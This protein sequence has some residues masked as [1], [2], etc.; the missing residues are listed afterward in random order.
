MTPHEWRA[1]QNRVEQLWGPSQKWKE[2][3]ALTERVRLISFDTASAVVDALILAEKHAPAPAMIIGMALAR[4]GVT[5][6]TPPGPED[7]DHPRFGILLEG[8][9]DVIGQDS[10]LP[11]GWRLGMCAVCHVEQRFPP[12]RLLTQMEL[13]DRRLASQQPVDVY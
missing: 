9:C 12:G 11:A 5:T 7:C 2:A 13:E 1:I 8:P 10:P 6:T 3:P 4:S